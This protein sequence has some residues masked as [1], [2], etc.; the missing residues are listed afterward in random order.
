MLPVLRVDP[1]LDS[2]RESDFEHASAEQRKAYNMWANDRRWKETSR[3]ANFLLYKT[4][5]DATKMAGL[6]VGVQVVTRPYHDEKRSASCACSTMLCPHLRSV[7]RRGRTEL[8]H[9]ATRLSLPKR[10]SVWARQSH[11]CALRLERLSPAERLQATVIQLTFPSSAC[12]SGGT[13]WNA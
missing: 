6:P 7:A 11:T 13:V 4:A 9:R 12:V 10:T 1:K 2:H 5:Y 3:V 8:T